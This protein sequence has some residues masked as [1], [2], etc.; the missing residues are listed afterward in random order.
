[1]FPF[2]L[3]GSMKCLTH[4]L[5]R[6]YSAP[7]CPEQ[8]QCV[9]AMKKK[10]GG[11]WWSAIPTLMTEKSLG[12]TGSSIAKGVAR[13]KFP[14]CATPPLA[15]SCAS[16]HLSFLSQFSS[17]HPCLSALVC[18]FFSGHWVSA[19]LFKFSTFLLLRL[20]VCLS[21]LIFGSISYGFDCPNNF[22]EPRLYL[23]SGA[24]FSLFCL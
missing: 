18:L 2:P 5:S 14:R 23:L 21:L 10:S 8:H 22:L 3:H 12:L 4:R 11:G 9:Q 6:T 7:V 16:I 19:A 13:L 24:K 17:S 15:N 20:F 1:M